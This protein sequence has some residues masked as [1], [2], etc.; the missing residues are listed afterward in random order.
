MLYSDSLNIELEQVT[1]SDLP[2]LQELSKCT[3]FETFAAQNSPE[4][5]AHYLT[6]ALS[7]QKITEECFA[8][9]MAILKATPGSILWLLGGSD[10]VNQRLRAHRN[11]PAL[12]RM[13]PDGNGES[14]NPRAPL[15]LKRKRSLRIADT[16]PRPKPQRG[17]MR[18]PRA[19]PWECFAK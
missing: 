3:F 2:T 16:W 5:M 8:R 19:S 4:N 1:F 15:N 9:W 11:S 7:L 13:W 12:R 17:A 18:K 6:S 14:E 10:V